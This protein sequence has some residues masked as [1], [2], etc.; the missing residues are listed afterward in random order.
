MYL[1]YQLV[2]LVLLPLCNSSFEFSLWLVS[3]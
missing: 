2:L 3:C 1:K